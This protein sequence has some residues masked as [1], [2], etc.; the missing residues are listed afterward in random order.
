MNPETA[1][2]K[3]GFAG[4]KSVWDDLQVAHVAQVQFIHTVVCHPHHYIN[5]PL[6]IL[7]GCV[8]GRIPSLA[9]LVYDR[10]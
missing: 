7:S 1:P 9:S 5:A 6:L 10:P 8:V 2:S 4:A 3:T